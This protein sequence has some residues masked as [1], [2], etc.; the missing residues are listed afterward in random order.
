MSA[1]KYFLK[2]IFVILVIYSNFGKCS[3]AHTLLHRQQ[4]HWSL[5]WLDKQI[6]LYKINLF[7]I[8]SD[9]ILRDSPCTFL[10]LT[11]L[12]SII[13]YCAVWAWKRYSGREEFMM[14]GKSPKFQFW[15]KVTL[16][17][18]LGI[19][20]EAIWLKNIILTAKL[21][22]AHFRVIAWILSDI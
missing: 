18:I 22:R 12:P 13:K 5:Y 14:K 10:E 20:K 7:R 16:K 4:Y 15:L 19:I 17:S 1:I 21:L 11:T 3:V 9:L 8:S 2:Q 6:L